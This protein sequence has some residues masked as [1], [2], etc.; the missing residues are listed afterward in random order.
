MKRSMEHEI[1]GSA[2]LGERGQLVIPKEIRD[3][4][5]LMTGDK[6]IIMGHDN[7]PIVFLPV[8]QMKKFL[9]HFNQ[10]IKDIMDE[11]AL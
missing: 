7:G 6:F 2:V 9:D 10:K 8:K 5:K 1:L 4:H 3:S 11:N